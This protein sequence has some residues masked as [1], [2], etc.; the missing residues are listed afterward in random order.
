M[1]VERELAAAGPLREREHLVRPGE[2]LV[3]AVGVPDGEVG[4]AQDPGQGGG[5][6]GVAG[7]LHR[8]ADERLALAEVPGPVGRAGQRG[9]QP[10]AQARRAVRQ[11]GQR[12]LE[13]CDQLGVGHPDVEPPRHHRQR[14]LREQLGPAEVAGDVG[15][16]PERLARADRVATAHPRLAQGEQQPGRA[17]AHRILV[18]GELEGA[19]EVTLGLFEGQAPELVAAGPL[20]QRGGP[21][22]ARGR[23]VVADLDQVLVGGGA[24]ERLQRLPHRLVQLRAP[25]RREVGV[26][27][28]PDQRM[29]E[30]E[31]LEPPGPARRHH[32]GLR[33]LVEPGGEDAAFQPRGEA[34][35]PRPELHPDDGGGGQRLRGLGRQRLEPAPDGRADAVGQPH[36]R[37]RAQQAGDLAGE[38]RVAAGESV[39]LLRH[40][41]GVGVRRLA[42]DEVGHPA[43]SQAAERDA[44]GVAAELAE[45]V[46]CLS[47]EQLLVER[48]R[49][50]GRRVQVGD[51][52]VQEPQRR[53]VGGVQV[54]EQQDERAAGRDRAQ[55]AQHRV[56]QGEARRV[57]VR[58]HR[59]AGAVAEQRRDQVAEVRR[60]GADRRPQVLGLQR[61]RERAQDLGPR[62]EGG[63]AAAGRPRPRPTGR[64]RPRRPARC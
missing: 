23:E 53:R 25:R 30:G 15:G 20:G 36:R 18:A 34:E 49:Q 46:G 4:V 2:R 64:S 47:V 27:R 51:D 45:Q 8:L 10:G 61:G 22:A 13:A 14:R 57:G 6:A 58:L 3:V 31:A 1:A 19:L 44:A 42:A 37:A 9:E 24:V 7:E 28:L 32:T 11:P 63:R 55:E 41:V 62:P 29:G 52:E 26:Q 38:E 39:D 16:L 33:R 40:A 43:L 54:V 60:A 17:L 12:L 56:E 50:H 5:V 48:Q 21:R 35:R 59:R